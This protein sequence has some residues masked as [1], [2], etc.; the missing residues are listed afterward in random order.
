MAKMEDLDGVTR[1]GG[2]AGGGTIF[3]VT[4]SGALT[5]LHNFVEGS[6]DGWSLKVG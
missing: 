5:T 3:K 1:T 6:D 4:S 2:K